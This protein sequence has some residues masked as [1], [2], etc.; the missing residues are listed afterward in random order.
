M[1]KHQSS[2]IEI[3]FLNFLQV[4]VKEV[5]MFLDELPSPIDKQSL[6]RESDPKNNYVPCFFL[7]I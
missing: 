7:F 1:F 4:S 3:I 2:N 6:N 5:F